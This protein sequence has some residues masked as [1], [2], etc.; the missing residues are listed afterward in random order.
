LS[1]SESK[2]HFAA[3]HQISWSLLISGIVFSTLI[4]FVDVK[5][6]DLD[7]KAYDLDIKGTT[8]I[9]DWPENPSS[10][11]QD[12][13][14][15]P[16]DYSRYDFLPFID[17]LAIQYLFSLSSAASSVVSMHFAIS[18]SAGL[19]GIVDGQK[20]GSGNIPPG[21]VIESIDLLMDVLVGDDSVAEFFLPLDT[22]GLGPSPSMTFVDIKDVSWS[23][24][25]MDTNEEAEVDSLPFGCYHAKALEIGG[26]FDEAT[27][28]PEEEYGR[29]LLDAGG[30]IVYVPAIRARFRDSKNLRE[31]AGTYWMRGNI[32]GGLFGSR[33]R[34]TDP[35]ELIPS[36]LVVGL[37]VLFFLSRRTKLARWALRSLA[38]L[39]VSRTFQAASDAAEDSDSNPVLTFVASITM[40]AT[41]GVGFIRGL[42][43]GRLSR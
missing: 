14:A 9:K 26:E 38:G 21:F 17:S 25:F 15:P 19:V 24:V 22:I 10:R 2:S 28:G 31:V 18:W 16:L 29:R 41:F 35:R 8:W 20:V 36:A 4:S 30:T 39:V 34:R 13:S 12:E 40:T 11:R 23:S 6:Q 27:A 32:R 5:A 3:L 7:V 43:K 42:V 33:G 37:P 1:R